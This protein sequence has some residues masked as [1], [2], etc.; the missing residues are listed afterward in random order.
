M[1]VVAKARLGVLELA[2]QHLHHPLRRAGRRLGLHHPDLVPA[3]ALLGA[4]ERIGQRANQPEGAALTVR[5]EGRIALTVELR[6][7]RH[8]RPVEDVG[9]VALDVGALFLAD[10]ALE[11]VEPVVDVGLD[12]L[13][14]QPAVRTEPRRAPVVELERLPGPLLPVSGHRAL[15]SAEVGLAYVGGGEG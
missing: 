12:D 1:R 4:A 8:R 5:A 14:Q 6:F 2:E 3:V 15:F 11:D 10:H 7:R 9:D 13:G